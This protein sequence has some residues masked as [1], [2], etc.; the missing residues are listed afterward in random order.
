MGLFVAPCYFAIG[1]VLSN[2][3]EHKA[4]NAKRVH[5]LGNLQEERSRQC[6]FFETTEW[7]DRSCA[8]EG[9]HYK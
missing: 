5:R 3:Y 2:E 7:Y 8:Q 1:V 4:S 9:L 6:S